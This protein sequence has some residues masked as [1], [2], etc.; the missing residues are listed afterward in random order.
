MRAAEEPGL[1]SGLG[2]PV[3]LEPPLARNTSRRRPTGEAERLCS[4]LCCGMA[5]PVL[6]RL[7]GDEAESR[8]SVLVGMVADRDG[9]S[10]CVRL[11]LGL[12]LRCS[13]CTMGEEVV[14]YPIWE[15]CVDAAPGRAELLQHKG[16]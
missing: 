1:R 7:K 11:G 13:S 15:A 9:R 12:F 14:R 5:R 2:L 6:L 16:C 3:P 4:S 10:V 8:E